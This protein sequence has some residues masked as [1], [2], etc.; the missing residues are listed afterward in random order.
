MLVNI[1]S[2]IFEKDAPRSR[3]LHRCAASVFFLL[4]FSEVGNIKIMSLASLFFSS[5]LFLSFVFLR[6]SCGFND[7]WNPKTLP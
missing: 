5:A 4:S 3:H 1:S 2:W 6:R 7:N